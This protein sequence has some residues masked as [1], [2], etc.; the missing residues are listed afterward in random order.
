MNILIVDDNA[1]ILD[2]IKY[3][4]SKHGY[5]VYCA[6]SG[7]EAMEIILNT[8]IAL[9]ILDIML[10]KIDG[11]SLCRQIRKSFFFPILFLTSKV[12]EEDKINGLVCGGDDYMLKPFFVQR[13]YGKSLFFASKK[14]PL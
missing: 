6:T 9:A 5:R 1:E 13:A 4:L 2:I 3:H 8:P 12:S 11:F 7:E 14:Y 10:P